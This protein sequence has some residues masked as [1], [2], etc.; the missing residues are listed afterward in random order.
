MTQVLE[1]EEKTY[2]IHRQQLLGTDEGKFVLIREDQ[3]A[4]VYD[5]KRDAIAEGYKQFGNIPFLVKRI[6]KVETPQNFVSNLLGV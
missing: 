6:I 1:Q 2:E 3:V 5:S 4:G